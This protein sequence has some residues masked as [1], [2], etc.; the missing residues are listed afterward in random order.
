M[1]REPGS[2]RLQASQARVTRTRSLPR[3]RRRLLGYSSD[4]TTKKQHDK[5]IYY[6]Q[7]Q[8]HQ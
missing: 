4:I 8:M 2:Y 5:M 7:F 6:G 3:P 1:I